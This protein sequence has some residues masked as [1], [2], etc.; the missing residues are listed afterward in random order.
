VFEDMAKAKTPRS[1]AGKQNGGSVPAT[2]AAAHAETVSA[3]KE[4]R[5]GATELRSS[6]VPINLDEEIRLRA[7]QLWEQRGRESGHENEHWL[8]AEREILARYQ[9]GRQ[10]SA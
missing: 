2:E 10:Q 8:L 9:S 7:Y 4:V 5:K 1:N 6:V 3:I